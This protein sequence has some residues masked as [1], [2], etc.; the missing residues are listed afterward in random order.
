MISAYYDFMGNSCSMSGGSEGWEDGDIKLL[1]DRAACSL[2]D[3]VSC[4]KQRGTDCAHYLSGSFAF[5]LFDRK[6][7]RL[8]VV[9]DKLGERPIYYAQLP[10]GIQFSSELGS[11]LPKI[12]Y[13]AIRPHEL[14]QP[15]RHNYPIE[16][17]HTW[18]EQIMR[19]R[20]GEYAVVDKDGLRLYNYFKR[21]YKPTFQ[22][23]KAEAVQESLRLMR[24]SVKRC[25]ETSSG[26]VAVMLSGGMDSSSLAKFA[27][28]LQQEVHV[29]SAGYKGNQYTVCD[30]RSVAR[31]F[32]E[33][34]GLVFHDVELDANDFQCYLDELMPHLDEPAFD[35][36]CMVQ[37]AVYKKAAEMGFNSILSGVGG[38][39]QFYGYRDMNRLAKAI[40]QNRDFVALYPVSQNKKALF[41]YIVRNFKRLL[42]P[43][44]SAIISGKNPV[45]WT[46]EDYRKF[47]YYGKL[48]YHDEI[49]EFANIDV[50]QHFSEDMDVNS[51]YD[52]LFSTF[53]NTLCVYMGN[54]LSGACG[55]DIR[56]PLLDVDLVTF[57][58]SL[59]LEMKFDFE[60]PKQFQK[61]IMAGLLPDYVLNGKKHG[62]EPPF[63]FIWDMCA[64]YEYKR[65]NAD[66]V[67]FNSMVADRMIDNLL[68]K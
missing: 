66:H 13:P 7:A 65:I 59:P 51:L 18:I 39:E 60:R 27:K 12:V 28:E 30:E 49:I 32:A 46:Y 26:P 1:I 22:G 23:T 17:Q 56:Y 10:T 48:S 4:Y 15:I 67:F 19:L 31:R 61:E 63:E 52:Y 9:R 47:A 64:K 20:A 29:F 38:D 8:L 43:T 68:Y 44:Q 3:I 58:D 37:Y 11:I 34:N 40:K 53:A 33:E 42:L 35:V 57:L 14:A 45:M 16:L 5:M 55:I 6:E 25:L 24:Q 2:E 36:S 62:F 54:K 21:D 50:T 41:A